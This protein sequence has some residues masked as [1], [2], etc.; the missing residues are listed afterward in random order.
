MN[1]NNFTFH[2]FET[3]IK[4]AF[5]FGMTKQEP[6]EMRLKKFIFKKKWQV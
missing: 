4:K 1:C 3:F 2:L 6:V 5:K